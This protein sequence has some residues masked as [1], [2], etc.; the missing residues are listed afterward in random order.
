ML[1]LIVVCAHTINN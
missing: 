1:K